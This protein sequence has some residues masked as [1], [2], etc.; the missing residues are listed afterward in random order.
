[1]KVSGRDAYVGEIAERYD[2]DR[3]V[4]EIWEKEQR[5]VEQ[6]VSS[7]GND[8][9]VLDIPSGTGRFLEM[10]LEKGLAVIAADISEDMLSVAKGKKNSEG[11]VKFQIEDA[12]ALSL[13][14]NSCD[15]IICWRLAHLLSS[16]ALERVLSEFSRVAR[17]SVIIQFYRVEKE[18]GYIEK[19]CLRVKQF[20]AAIKKILLKVCIKNCAA[21]EGSSGAAV[22]PWEHIETFTHAHQHIFLASKSVGLSIVRVDTIDDK[23][24][25]E[26]IYVFKKNIEAH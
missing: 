3:V 2:C 22:T 25:G 8:E 4:E 15:H 23:V 14:D 7:F 6:L 20:C 17:K 1:M 26:N 18:Q 24:N 10:Y 12:C 11:S 5:Y 16:S 21:D 19:I 9:T 13:S